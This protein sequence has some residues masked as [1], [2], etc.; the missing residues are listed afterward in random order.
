[1]IWRFYLFHWLHS[2]KGSAQFYIKRFFH[3]T[4]WW[5]KV[6]HLII[7]KLTTLKY[8][9]HGL[10]FKNQCKPNTQVTWFHPEILKS[11]IHNIYFNE[12]LSFVPFQQLISN[13]PGKPFASQ[14]HL[15]AFNQTNPNNPNPNN[16]APL[17]NMALNSTSSS[18]IQQQHNHN[19]HSQ[20]PLHFNSIQINA[21]NTPNNN[22][23]NINNNGNN[24]NNNNNNQNNNIQYVQQQQ[25]QQL[26]YMASSPKH[27]NHQ[28]LASP[29]NYMG[30]GS[31]SGGNTLVNSGVNLSGGSGT[32]SGGMG[33]DSGSNS[34]Q[35]YPQNFVNFL[36]ANNS[37]TPTSMPVMAIKLSKSVQVCAFI[38]SGKTRTLFGLASD[39]FAT[40]W[41]N[42]L[43][44][45][46][47]FAVPLLPEKKCS[48]I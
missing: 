37:N 12:K 33:S 44:W 29:V 2:L 47:G 38:W 45:C 3:Q 13:S 43:K 7:K 35:M 40:K 25:Q 32:G 30:P 39:G 46:Y 48:P 36:T 31:Y 19:S 4:T 20:S 14:Q 34:N 16:Q 28:N 10:K 24:N 18:V 1:M 8:K 42:S 22:S 5:K 15:S 26:N 11:Q 9:V 27:S 41:K 6:N 17:T 23:N 21:N